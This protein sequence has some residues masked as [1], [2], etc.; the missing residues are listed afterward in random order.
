MIKKIYYQR[1]GKSLIAVMLLLLFMYLSNGVNG[2][3]YWQEQYDYLHSEKFIKH[4]YKEHNLHIKDYDNKEKPVYYDS[5][6]DYRDETLTI[7]QTNTRYLLTFKERIPPGDIKEQTKVDYQVGT[8]YWASYFSG[9]ILTAFLIFFSGFLLFF[10]DQKTNFNRFLFSLPVK[11]RDLFL[12]KLVYLGLPLLGSV[13]VGTL[14]YVLLHYFGVPQPYMNV[15]LAQLFYSGLGHFVF[16]VFALAGGILLGTVLG[17]LV[18]GPLSLLAGLFFLIQGPISHAYDQLN[19]I[20][21]YFFPD[22]RFFSIEAI[23]IMWPTKT[24][25]PW[26]ALVSQLLIAGLFLF[27]AERV[28]QQISMENDGDYVTVPKLRLPVFL[29]IF[30]GLTLYLSLAWVGWYSFLAPD[31]EGSP[32]STMFVLTVFIL[33]ASFLLVYAHVIRKWWLERRDLRLQA[34]N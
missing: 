11:R 25:A 31:M 20:L 26:Y 5:I 33:I 18:F 8:S 16:M 27:L 7:Y 15:T 13:A 17:N 22:I 12:G 6:D 34:K 9:N 30:I 10:V 29:T 32:W 14:G 21:T 23:F 1:Y 3:S 24:G 2:A 28:Y 19:L 4:E